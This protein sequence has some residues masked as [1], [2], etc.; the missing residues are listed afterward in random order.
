MV[1]AG[2]GSGGV[3]AKG[4]DLSRCLSDQSRDGGIVGVCDHSRGPGQADQNFS[5]E[6]RDV[7][8]FTVSIEL[9]AEQICKYDHAR[10]SGRLDRWKHRLVDL[11]ERA[12]A[13]AVTQ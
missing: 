11:E 8:D 5:P 1:E 7:V 6:G 9:I 3:D 13:R 4:D 2:A 10:S 12:I